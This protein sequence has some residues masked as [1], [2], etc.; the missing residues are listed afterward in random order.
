M[1]ELQGY[2]YPPVTDVKG[3][4]RTVYTDFFS[5]M[6]PLDKDNFES[7]DSQAD[8]VDLPMQDYTGEEYIQTYSHDKPIPS[9]DEPP[10]PRE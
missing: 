9:G 5:N 10:K 8:P 6:N 2:L 1:F 3:E 7:V 4:I